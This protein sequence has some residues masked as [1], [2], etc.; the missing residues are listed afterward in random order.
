MQFLS[1]TVVSTVHAKKCAECSDPNNKDEAC[2]GLDQKHARRHVDQTC[3][4][5]SCCPQEHEGGHIKD[6]ILSSTSE[7]VLSGSS[8]CWAIIPGLSEEETTEP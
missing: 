8:K 1:L 3:N 7:V 2:S 6:C 5:G 4:V